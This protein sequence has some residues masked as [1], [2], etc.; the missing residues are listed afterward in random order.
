MICSDGRNMC[1]CIV[2][3]PWPEKIGIRLVH[4]M[5][6]FREGRKSLTRPKYVFKALISSWAIISRGGG[7]VN[8]INKI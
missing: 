3:S 1:N 7:G 8:I 2:D 5:G 4:V 6:R